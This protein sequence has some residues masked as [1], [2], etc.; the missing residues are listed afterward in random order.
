[1]KTKTIADRQKTYILK[2]YANLD[3]RYTPPMSA[4]S[5]ALLSNEHF[6]G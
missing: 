5:P 1:M 3:A 4:S 6:A 2:S